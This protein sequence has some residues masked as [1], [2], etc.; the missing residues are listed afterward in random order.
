MSFLWKVLVPP[1][2]WLLQVQAQHLLLLPLLRI[3]TSITSSS[4][5]NRERVPAQSLTDSTDRSAQTDQHSQAVL[6]LAPISSPS[7]SWVN[8]CPSLVPA[9]LQLQHP[10]NAMAP[11]KSSHRTGI[12]GIILG[13]HDRQKAVEGLQS[14]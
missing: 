14:C 9:W 4:G 1:E 13:S 7:P 5:R 8:L 11:P 10:R 3:H 6:L 12:A 2:M